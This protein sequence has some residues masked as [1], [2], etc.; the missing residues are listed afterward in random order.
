MSLNIEL[1][2]ASTA[3]LALMEKLGITTKPTSQSHASKLIYTEQ[4]RLANRMPTEKQVKKVAACGN[5]TSWIGRDLPGVRFRE[6][7]FQIELLEIL[8]SFDKAETQAGLNSAAVAMIEK[9]RQRLTKVRRDTSFKD[10]A[11]TPAE[12]DAGAP[13]APF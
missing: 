8:E 11:V 12:D 4:A 9:V 1:R 3:T 10:V 6:V 13:D 5:D 7:S 2:P